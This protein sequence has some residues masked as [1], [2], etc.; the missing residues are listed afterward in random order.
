MRLTEYSSDV[1]SAPLTGSGYMLGDY[2]GLV[3]PLVEGQPAV[4]LTIDTRHGNPDPVAVRYALSADEN[5]AAW[6]TA[7][8][9]LAELADTAESGIEADPDGDDFANL[10]EYALGTNPRVAES[11][12]AWEATLTAPDSV[13]LAQRVRATNDFAV[14]YERQDGD[15]W[16]PLTP[17]LTSFATATGGVALGTASATLQVPAPA[18]LRAAFDLGGVGTF[19]VATPDRYTVGGDARLV[20]VSTRGAVG[21]DANQLIVGFVLDG[22]KSV[23]VRGAGPLLTTLGVSN[24]LADPQLR[25]VRTGDNQELATND[26][27]GSA[28][29]APA[30]A[31]AAA[32]LGATALA[33]ASRDAA[34]LTTLPAGV[35][36]AL[37]T[38]ANGTTGIGLGEIYDAD[39]SPGAPSGPRLTNLSARGQVGATNEATL[40]AGFV[41]TGTQPRRVLLRAAGPGLSALGVTTPLADPQLTLFHHRPGG[42]EVI[43]SNDDWSLARTPATTLEAT[44]TRVGAFA[45][46]AGSVDSALLLSLA[47]GVYTAQVTGPAGQSGVALVEVYDAD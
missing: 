19:P 25:L 13:T 6:Q 3:P 35:Y 27:W 29:A 39:D 21:T 32:R 14:R 11:G 28:A 42:A 12:T 4:A 38:G 45:F 17:A 31:Q 36:T 1:R 2:Q 10:A 41:I 8:F 7:R 30:L 43:A 18:V 5:F 37:I 47:P 24:A 46:P 20:N 9:T 26:D 40:I 15:A 23:L 22:G 33:D 16:T 44:A 34:L